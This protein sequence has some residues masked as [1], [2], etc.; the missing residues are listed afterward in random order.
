M[1][2]W[3]CSGHWLKCYTDKVGI[4]DNFIDRD[5]IR[6]LFNWIARRSSIDNKFPMNGDVDIEKGYI[7]TWLKN[8]VKRF[9]WDKDLLESKE[10]EKRIELIIDIALEEYLWI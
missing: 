7:I 4:E 5:S 8:N 9:R 6:I 1:K 3:S 2:R 10:L